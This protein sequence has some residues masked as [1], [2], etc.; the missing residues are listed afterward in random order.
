MMQF[1]PV[2]SYTWHCD[3]ANAVVPISVEKKAGVTVF[4]VTV[5][6]SPFGTTPCPYCTEVLCAPNGKSVGLPCVLIGCDCVTV[7]CGVNVQAI[8]SFC[9][10]PDPVPAVKPL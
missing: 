7:V 3:P 2:S 5:I 6:V 8:T 1:P 10:S 9:S 4:A